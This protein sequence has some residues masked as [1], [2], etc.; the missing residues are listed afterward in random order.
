MSDLIWM[1]VSAPV[2]AGKLV[3]VGPDGKV[4][5]AEEKGARR[6]YSTSGVK[7]DPE[8]RRTTSWGSLK[9]LPELTG[10]LWDDFALGVVMALRPSWIRV[11][12]GEETTDGRPWRVT[13]CVDKAG[14][15]QSIEQEVEFHAQEMS[16]AEVM[17]KLL[18]QP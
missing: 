6:Y 16:G 11:T 8:E 1:P 15:I 10:K 17:E 7:P 9:M 2:D 5:Q 12:T 4:R 3:A 14:I 18:E 13:V